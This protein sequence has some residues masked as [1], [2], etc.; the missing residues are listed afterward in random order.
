M[1]VHEN[2]FDAPTCARMCAVYSFTRA[3]KIQTIGHEP[4]IIARN[5]LDE[6]GNK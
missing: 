2:A 5:R 6:S 1:N 3:R 4:V